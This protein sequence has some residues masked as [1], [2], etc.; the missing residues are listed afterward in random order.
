MNSENED[1]KRRNEDLKRSIERLKY[2]KEN[3]ELDLREHEEKLRTWSEEPARQRAKQRMLEE[4]AM[5]PPDDLRKRLDDWIWL[6]KQ[7][8]QWANW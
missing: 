3:A 5:L 8:G 6:M 1:L 2:E 4:L 7:K